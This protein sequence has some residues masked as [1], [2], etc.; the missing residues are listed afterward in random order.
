MEGEGEILADTLAD[1]LREADGERDA[2]ADA[3]VDAL[4]DAD[5]DC[6]AEGLTLALGLIEG[7]SE[8]DGLG[9]A[10]GLREGEPIAAISISAQTFTPLVAPRVENV[11]I[12]NSYRPSPL[13]GHWNSDSLSKS[14]TSLSGESVCAPPGSVT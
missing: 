11:W 2:D 10:D 3:L 8:A 13:A 7:L 12:Q 14:G 1:G 5:G 9:L 4:A 6:E